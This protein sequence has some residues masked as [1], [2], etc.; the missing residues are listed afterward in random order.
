MRVGADG[1]PTPVS[2]V[3]ELVDNPLPSRPRADPQ[4][5]EEVAQ[6]QAQEEE[7]ELSQRLQQQNLGNKK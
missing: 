4:N 3:L 2:H 5:P 7:E 6:A 1:K